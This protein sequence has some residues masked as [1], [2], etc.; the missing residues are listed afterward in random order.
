MTAGEFTVGDFA[1]FVYFLGFVSE[2]VWVLGMFIARYQQARVSLQRMTTLLAGAPPERL[3]EARDLQLTGPLPEP[4]A[5]AGAAEPLRELR[6]E[7][8]TCHYPG[9][10]AGIE[11][12]DLVLPGG[13]FTVVTGRIG[14]GK[15]T[16]LRRR[17]G[18][19][20]GRCRARCAGTAR[21]WP[22]RPSSS[23]RRAP[24]TRRRC[25]ACSR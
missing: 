13:S 25:P 24:P 1:L 20:A 15:T 5:D 18:P 12:V 6:V 7:G 22:T 19:A 10:T 23:C 16:L 8:L 4:A 14:S 21:W 11:D 9:T 2:C 17:P 3:V